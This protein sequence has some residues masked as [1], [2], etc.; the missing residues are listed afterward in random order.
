MLEESEQRFVTVINGLIESPY[1]AYV[2]VD[3][4]A[5]ITFMNQTYLTSWVRNAPRLSGK[6]Y[7]RS[8]PIPNFL[9][10]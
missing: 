10:Y 6:T 4:D 5:N 7:W 9:K 8:P 3:K 2:I 1:L